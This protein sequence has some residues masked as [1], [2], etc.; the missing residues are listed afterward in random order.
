MIKYLPKM[1]KIQRKATY[2]HSFPTFT[3]QRRS[4]SRRATAS[5]SGEVK[6]RCLAEGHL[7]T[8]ATR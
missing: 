5:L 1:I 8:L 6:V 3:H 7:D 4:Q 2:N